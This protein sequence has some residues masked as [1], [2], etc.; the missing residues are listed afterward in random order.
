MGRPESGVKLFGREH[1]SELLES[2]MGL[3][4]G[5]EAS[6]LLEDRIGLYERYS[7][8]FEA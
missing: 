6:S 5:G 8:E 7:D 2:N 3:W 1:L 4:D